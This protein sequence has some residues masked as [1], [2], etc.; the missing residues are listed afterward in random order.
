MNYYIYVTDYASNELIGYKIMGGNRLS[1]MTAGPFKTGNEP[2]A[3]AIAP[4]PWRSSVELESAGVRD[5]S[6]GDRG[7]DL[8]FQRHESFIRR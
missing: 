6:E 4:R 1:Y 3:I 7:Q 8:L 2:S 5:A